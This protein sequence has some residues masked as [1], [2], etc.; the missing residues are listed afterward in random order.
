MVTIVAPLCSARQRSTDLEGNEGTLVL[1]TFS[2]WQEPV[3]NVGDTVAKRQLLARGTTHIYFQANVWIFTVLVF[4][5]GIMMG[6]GKAAVYKFIPEYY[7]RDVGV[8]GGVVGVIGGLGGF[9]CP[10]I[11]GYLLKWTGIWT[12]AWM[13]FFVIT[14]VCHAWMFFVVRRIMRERTPELSRHIEDNNGVAVMEIP[15]HMLADRSSA[16]HELR[17][18][19]NIG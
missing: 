5:V 15:A 9:V 2:S 13:F 17:K 10:I 19:S 12:T 4:I 7:P 8:V 16:A 14:L 18:H 11:F 1:P 6:I 3:V